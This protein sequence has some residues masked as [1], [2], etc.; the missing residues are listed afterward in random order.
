[1]KVSQSIIDAVK[2]VME[3]G[4]DKEKTSTGMKVY[5]SSYGDS[6][7]ARKDQ[8]K[9]SVDTEKGPSSAEIKKT[10][11][12]YKPHQ[13]SKE[14]SYNQFGAHMAKEEKEEGHEDAA[15]DKAM[16]KDVAK[17]EVK[18]HEKKMHHKEGYDFTSRLVASHYENELVEAQIQEVLSKDASAGDWIHDFIHSDNPKFK[19]KSKAMRKKM[20][21]AAYYAKQRNEEVEI[22]EAKVTTT[23][24]N[25]NRITTDMLRGRTEGGKAND[26][27]SFKLKLK[28][29]G[30]MKAPAKEEPHKTSA[31]KSI[32]TH[33]VSE[34]TIE[35]ETPKKGQDVS[36]KSWLKSAGKKPSPLHNVG[37]GLKAFMTGKKE[38]MESV[39]IDGETLGEARDG[40]GKWHSQYPQKDQF[41]GDELKKREFFKSMKSTDSMKRD[42]KKGLGFKALKMKEEVVDEAKRPEQDVVP[43]APPYETRSKDVIT[44]KSGAKHTPMSRAR[45]LA[46]MAALQQQKKAKK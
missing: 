19:G 7:K 6:K 18:K 15:E 42:M 37:K 32:E 1:M 39:E 38:P 43:F 34:E 2:N 9:S 16:C 26:F 30:E 8:T 29:D 36:D 31:R 46:R 44:D 20:A 14:K 12:A 45:H 24:E 3:S 27:K 4:W 21:L 41:Q 25:P 5:G 11:G 22:D 28:T 33:K 23:D 13:P 35:E 40:D 10:E 17:K